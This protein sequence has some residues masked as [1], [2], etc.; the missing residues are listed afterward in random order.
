MWLW[1]LANSK[2]KLWLS[3]R[4]GRGQ[5]ETCAKLKLLLC[6]WGSLGKVSALPLR[7]FS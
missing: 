7:T 1:G 4:E 2:S 5:T 3:G 6:W